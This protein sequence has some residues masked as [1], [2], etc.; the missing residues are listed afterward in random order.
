MTIDGLRTAASTM[1]SPISVSA[2]QP[3]QA[4]NLTQE[5]LYP[6]LESY[7]HNNGLYDQIMYTMQ[8]MGIWSP[9]MKPLRNPANRVV[10][11]YATKLCPG[12]L[13]M[14]LPLVAENKKIIQPIQQIWTWS[15]WAAKK[16]VAARWMPLFGDLF[17]KIATTPDKKRVYWQLVKP[18]KVYDFDV[19]DRGYVTSMR[20]HTPI[21][22]GENMPGLHIEYWDKTQY[23]EWQVEAT[24]TNEEIEQL[25]APM[26]TI[27]Y[28]DWGIDFPPI[29]HAKFR[30][31]G[32][33]RGVGCFVHAMDKIDEANRM[34]T[35]LHQLLFRY[36]KATWAVSA[37]SVDSSGRPLPPPTVKRVD[38][39]TAVSVPTATDINDDD[40][41]SLPGMSTIQSL[42][43]GIAW[44]DALAVLNAQLTE[45]EHDLPEL[46]YY[47]LRD[48]S[49]LSG[50]AVRLL[51]SDAFDRATEARGNFEQAL[52]R[53]DQISLTIADKLGVLPEDM[54]DLGGTYEEGA[55]D[56]SFRDR[57]IYPV[58]PQ[59]RAEIVKGYTDATI[60][61]E[62]AMKF[63]GFDD[64]EIKLAMDAQQ[65]ATD[66]AN[67]SMSDALLEAQRKFD[68][69]RSTETVQQSGE[70][71]PPTDQT[72]TEPKPTEPTAKP[73]PTK[74]TPKETTT[75]K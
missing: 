64:T 30:D 1:V 43:P 66:Q 12:S 20:I 14:A 63:A 13:P 10:E 19:D 71:T 21:K 4:N 65:K 25:G 34:A 32:Y 2:V 48:K 7:Y 60:P 59:E 17:I 70:T 5:G 8:E 35:R 45:I 74:T 38:S 15:N 69:G 41:F 39:G 49:D 42:S 6:Y 31:V 44:G 62:A 24:A 16:Q 29:V 28:T 72:T 18:E 46:A 68:S 47:N 9:A 51:L 52:I 27:P 57:P 11:F 3:F 53:A 73:A 37:N 67:K 26:K 40:F 56:H 36:N 55:F 22:L 75:T 61:L 58:T 50:K 33:K 54:S 23:R